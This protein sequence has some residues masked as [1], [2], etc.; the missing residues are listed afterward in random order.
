LTPIADEIYLLDWQ[1]Q[2]LLAIPREDWP[3]LKD[4]LEPP[5]LEPPRTPPSRTVLVRRI[6]QARQRTADFLVATS[7]TAEEVLL[8]PWR[9][10]PLW[11][12]PLWGLR[13]M[14]HYLTLVAGPT[15]WMY[16]AIAG[17]II[18]FVTTY[19]TFRFL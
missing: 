11:R 4:Q 5:S 19:F 2:S 13:W 6:N 10:L 9:L 3:N 1:S 7:R 18:G 15:A 17:A 8:T 12:S 16:I 14:W